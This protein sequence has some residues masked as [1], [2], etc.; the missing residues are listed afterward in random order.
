MF[1]QSPR[2]RSLLVDVFA[3]VVYGFFTG[4]AVEVLLSG[5]SLQQSLWSRLL[6]IPVNVII[7][8]PFS[9]YRDVVLRLALLYW[10]KQ[11][12][13]RNV[14]DL[15]SYV[16]FQSPIYAVILFAVGA[17]Y[18]LLLTA[19]ASNAIASMVLGVAYGYFLE[20]C[21]RLFRVSRTLPGTSAPPGS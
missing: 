1:S 15:L 12:W 17:E 20:Y 5:M 7:A 6:A 18:R 21:R 16:S 2:L 3:M 14:A 10:P 9:Q 4:I 8:W 19:L 11:F 13:T